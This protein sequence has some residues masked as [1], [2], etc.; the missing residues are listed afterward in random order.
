LYLSAIL[1]GLIAVAGLFAAPPDEEWST[2]ASLRRVFP[3]EAKP[4]GHWRNSGAAFLAVSRF[5]KAVQSVVRLDRG[6]V[7]IRF[8]GH[9]RTETPSTPVTSLDL[10]GVS[11]ADAVVLFY[12]EP[13]M[14]RSAIS[15]DTGQGT[16]KRRYILTGLAPGMWEVWRNGWVVDPGVR[17]RAGEGVLY[18]EERPGSY[19]IRRLN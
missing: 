12:R 1:T 5:G 11:V 17:V 7:E 9:V 18:F 15:F 19:F 13:G 4:V 14:V 3:P 16:G 10:E 2:L 8:D 6:E